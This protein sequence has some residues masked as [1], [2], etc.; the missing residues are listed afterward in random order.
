MSEKT[1]QPQRSVNFDNGIP[2]NMQIREILRQEVLKQ[3]IVDENG[4][5]PTELELVKRFGVSRIT[6]RNALQTLVDEGLLVRERGRGT[7]LKTNQPENWVGQLMGFTETIKEAGFT[8]GAQ[9]LAKGV[10]NKFP[11]KV[12]SALNVQVVW[13]L[14]RIR[15]ADDK[16]IAI[17]WAFFPPEIGLEL[18]KQD[19]TTIAMYK[20]LEEELSIP[21][22]EAK[23]MISAVNA[24][25]EEALQL[26][27][28]DNEALLYMER[29]TYSD[30][31][32]PIEFLKAVYC[33]EYFSYM[34][35]L[36]RKH[37]HIGFQ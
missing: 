25:E 2:L 35:Q 27:I 34:I 1:T 15:Y 36:T 17:E 24:S 18:E 4:K 28:E 16:P 5:M 10:T 21:L 14:K 26:G 12:K 33:P 37:P 13:E 31:Q 32:K 8:P 7:F 20:C 11:S 22:K 30:D 6:V 19:L 29:V 23:Q 9:I 3:E